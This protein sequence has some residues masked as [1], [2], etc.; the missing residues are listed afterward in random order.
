MSAMTPITRPMDSACPPNS[1]MPP[2]NSSDRST[3]PCMAS[4]IRRTLSAPSRASSP[5]LSAASAARPARRVASTAV[6]LTSCMTEAVSSTRSRW[7]CAPRAASR[8]LAESDSERSTISREMPS[9][10]RAASA[11]RS[12]RACASASAWRSSVRS[13]YRQMPPMRESSMEL[14]SC[15]AAMFTRRTA[16]RRPVISTSRTTELPSRITRPTTVCRPASP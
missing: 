11:R 2:R 8:T 1:R 6:A 3:T 7:V 16:P 12:L 4:R 5:A 10:S 15:E 13:V 9:A 14:R